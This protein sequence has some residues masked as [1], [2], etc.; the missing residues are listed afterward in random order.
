[1]K[2]SR[3]YHIRDHSRGNAKTVP[4]A[5][6]SVRLFRALCGWAVSGISHLGGGSCGWYFQDPQTHQKAFPLSP[7]ELHTGEALLFAWVWNTGVFNYQHTFIHGLTF[8][9]PLQC[10]P[11]F[12][13]FQQCIPLFLKNLIPPL[14]S[15]FITTHSITVVSF[16]IIH[17]WDFFPIKHPNLSFLYLPL[18]LQSGEKVKSKSFKYENDVELKRGAGRQAVLVG[19]GGGGSLV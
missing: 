13:I 6:Q 8:C 11:S 3:Q 19:P 1:M 7:G 17:W 10:V 12:F 18:F 15:F 16:K 14:L 5:L 9:L 2:L 4:S